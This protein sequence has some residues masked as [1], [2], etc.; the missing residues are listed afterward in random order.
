MKVSKIDDT[1]NAERHYYKQEAIRGF[2]GW[3]REGLLFLY[4]Y[5]MELL[6]SSHQALLREMV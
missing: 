4:K 2:I 6:R 3:T 5:K 1:L